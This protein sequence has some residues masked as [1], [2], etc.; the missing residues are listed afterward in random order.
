MLIA[1]PPH[2]QNA[3]NASQPDPLMRAAQNDK[4]RAWLRWLVTLVVSGFLFAYLP[5]W[6]G[7]LWLFATLLAETVSATARARLAKGD[8]GV[9]RVYVG[10]IFAVSTLWIAHAL[11]L[12]AQNDDLARIAA[13]MD[14]FTVALYG[15]VGGHKDQRILLALTAPP[16]LALASLLI[17]FAWSQAPAPLALIASIATLGACLTIAANGLAM[18][19]SD[20]LLLS[21]NVEVAK[22]RDALETRVLERT[23]DLQ[24]AHAALQAASRAKS[25]FLRVMSHELRTPLNGILGYAELLAEDIEAGEAKQDDA[26]K[27]AAS[28]RR[29]LRLINDVLDLASLEAG[30]ISTGRE[31]TDLSALLAAAQHSASEIAAQNQNQITINIAP[32]ALF[33]ATDAKRLLQIV[34]HVLDNACKFT[35]GGQIKISADIKTSAEGPKL[36]IAIED[37]GVGMA[38][39]D[40]QRIFEPFEQASQGMARSHEGAGLG[41]AITQRL[42]TLLGGTLDVTSTLGQGAK[43]VLEL[44]AD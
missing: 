4:N 43:V 42:T 31:N 23:Q 15:A 38:K 19:R 25:E 41:L 16:L 35:N 11:M 21:A 8:C 30:Q 28:G 40:L 1:A 20:Q 22:E 44:P 39:E 6:I 32:E 33:V 18:H 5:F 12:W 17:G 34:R 37:T 27:I 26:L 14:L 24:K 13:L 36:I 10:A 29:L 7:A 2:D 9:A 3:A